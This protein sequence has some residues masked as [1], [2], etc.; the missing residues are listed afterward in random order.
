MGHFAGNTEASP[1]VGVAP[2]ADPPA[3]SSADPSAF[4]ELGPSNVLS[5]AVLPG[6]RTAAVLGNR[7]SSADPHWFFGVADESTNE[8]T[9]A[10]FFNITT[11]EGFSQSDTVYAAA[12][13]WDTANVYD[14]EGII[15]GSWDVTNTSAPCS[16]SNTWCAYFSTCWGS[17]TNT[18]CTASSGAWYTYEYLL[19]PN[20]K[21]E[22]EMQL[23]ELGHG[24]TLFNGYLYYMGPSNAHTLL[25]SFTEYRYGEIQFFLGW[26]YCLTTYPSCVP[27]YEPV[28]FTVYEEIYGTNSVEPFPAFNFHTNISVP[29][30]TQFNWGWFHAAA[31]GSSYPP[32][33]DYSCNQNQRVNQAV[34]CT[35]S[36][37]GGRES[38]NIDNLPYQVWLGNP[39]GANMYY[40][41]V[42]CA[43]CSFSFGVSMDPLADLTGGIPVSYYYNYCTLPCSD[44]TFSPSFSTV[45]SPG[46]GPNGYF[47][48]SA[49]WPGVNSYVMSL[50]AEDENATNGPIYFISQYVL[51]VSM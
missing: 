15:V 7:T 48:V 42:V 32:G 11:P 28:G 46:S 44:V 13:T 12:S 26:H 35:Y 22:E 29:A 36:F 37:S 16:G 51:V 39:F 38:I 14:Q 47:D 3:N 20:T 23:V 21:Y 33:P 45:Q 50:Y 5:N 2:V 24:I 17:T 8:T 40:V 4:T 34:Q 43:E 18:N 49:S 41:E 9:S 10:I 6:N 31:A 27:E 25:D 19:D 30:G 1:G